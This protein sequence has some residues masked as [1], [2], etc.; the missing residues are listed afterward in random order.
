MSRYVPISE[1]EMDSFLKD[2]GFSTITLE[3]VNE[4]VYGKLVAKNTSLRV[5]SSLV[6]GESRGVGEDAIRVVLATRNADKIK[7]CGSSRRVNRT[8]NWRDNLTNRI[9]GWFEMMG[10]SCPKCGAATVERKGAYGDFWG[11]TNYPECKGIARQ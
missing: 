4:K 8:K 7:V 9:E 11:C 2:K 1:E 10:P 3:G 5:Y 6:A